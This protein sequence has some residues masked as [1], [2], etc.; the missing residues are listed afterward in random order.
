MDD[1]IFCRIV[2]GETPCS[3]VCED[4]RTLTFMDIFPVTDGHTLV[5][6]KEHF[7]DIFEAD[8]GALAAVAATSLRVAK[9]I[10]A[11]LAPDGLGVFQLNRPAAGQT[12]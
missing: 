5:I 3:K 12:V 9:A 8:E 1:C 2:R 6:T 11:T 4:E 10:D 7:S